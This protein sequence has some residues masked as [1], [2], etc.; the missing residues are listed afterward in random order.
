MN[1]LTFSDIEPS[2]SQKNPSLRISTSFKAA[3]ER[4]DEKKHHSPRTTYGRSTKKIYSHNKQVNPLPSSM[5]SGVELF[6]TT[7]NVGSDSRPHIATFTDSSQTLSGNSSAA[8]KR[9]SSRRRSDMRGSSS[10]GNLKNPSPSERRNSLGSSS[11]KFRRT[12]GLMRTHSHRSMKSSSSSPHNSSLGDGA[13]P[14]NQLDNRRSPSSPVRQNSSF[15]FKR[16]S[17][18]LSSFSFPS[19]NNL[20]NAQLDADPHLSA[21]A[22]KYAL[23][24][25]SDDPDDVQ[26]LNMG[27]MR[28]MLGKRSKLS[29]FFSPYSVEK[30]YLTYFYGTRWN[31][32]RRFYLLCTVAC[33]AALIGFS[34]FHAPQHVWLEFCGRVGA[35]VVLLLATCVLCVMCHVA[36]FE[37][38]LV[39]LIVW[40]GLACIYFDVVSL[41]EVTFNYFFLIFLHVIVYVFRVRWIYSGVLLVFLITYISFDCVYN[42]GTLG[43]SF[44]AVLWIISCLCVM[45]AILDWR[46]LES[47]SRSTFSTVRTL[48][49]NRRVNETKVHESVR[50]LHNILPVHIIERMQDEEDSAS[51]SSGDDEVASVQSILQTKFYYKRSASVVFSDIV[52]FSTYCSQVSSRKLANNL[53]TLFKAFDSLCDRCKMDK[54]KVVGDAYVSLCLIPFHSK[55]SCEFALLCRKRVNRLSKELN[56]PLK[57]RI[58]IASGPLTVGVFGTHLVTFDA[59]GRTMRVAEMLEENSDVLQ[60][61]VDDKVYARTHHHFSYTRNENTVSLEG[62]DEVLD[63][64]YLRADA[65]EYQTPPTPSHTAGDVVAI[66]VRSSPKRGES[67]AEVKRVPSFQNMSTDDCSEEPGNRRSS[68]SHD[69]RSSPLHRTS[70]QHLQQQ[71]GMDEDSDSISNRMEQSSQYANDLKSET[72]SMIS[73]YSSLAS[74][75]LRSA[76]PSIAK[77]GD[78]DDKSA[79]GDGHKVRYRHNYFLSMFL[80]PLDEWQFLSQRAAV[81]R[82]SIVHHSALAVLASVGNFAAYL[83]SGQALN[84]LQGWILFGASIS[85]LL[86]FTTSL[87]ACTGAILICNNHKYSSSATLIVTHLFCLSN[88]MLTAIVPFFFLH[89]QLLVQMSVLMVIVFMHPTL[90]PFVVRLIPALT[91]VVGWLTYHMVTEFN[92]LQIQHICTLVAFVGLMGFAAYTELFSYRQAFVLEQ[93]VRL[94]TRKVETLDKLLDKLILSSLPREVYERMRVSRDTICDWMPS[95]CIMF[96]KLWGFSEEVLYSDDTKSCLAVLERLFNKYDE[97]TL[98]E[99]DVFKIKS[100]GEYYLARGDST[101]SVLLKAVEFLKIAQETLSAPYHVTIGVSTGPVVMAVLGSTRL[102]YDCF[103]TTVNLASRLCTTSEPS[104]V[105]VTEDTVNFLH[106]RNQDLALH[107][108]RRAEKVDL[109]GID[110]LQT[111][112]VESLNTAAESDTEGNVKS[113]DDEGSHSE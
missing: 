93:Q 57:I 48:E 59:F 7:D 71:D 15:N 10:S 90:V 112:F 83:A 102:N 80:S 23:K 26:V 63:T 77:N 9:D 87:L 110:V 72:S 101:L 5:R 85:H 18:F 56:W 49:V 52:N 36:L 12:S 22:A 66:Q 6:S 3:H 69:V 4:R 92:L 38:L 95:C 105:H 55:I 30:L 39:V 28:H 31:L 11:S 97:S 53:N 79:Q 88:M 62:T 99:S 103:S 40:L 107:F 58:G 67:P 32:K 13:D 94:E 70:S 20:F 98:E 84:A 60:I 8:Q 78:N 27:P 42:M 81:S 54:V 91:L 76:A 50:L 19:T 47:Q 82:G 2:N 37:M 17:S 35:F 64:Y 24:A 86:I 73:R 51:V 74:I 108:T 68:F 75:S 109:K 34:F 33:F 41:R 61:L 43:W 14:S 89:S 111:Y 44:H 45:L 106:E 29:L 21:I 96:L 113:P 25:S 46:R 1:D 100:S 16:R 104:R 65:N